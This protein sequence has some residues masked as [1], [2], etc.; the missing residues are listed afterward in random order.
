[1][2][3]PASLDMFKLESCS[4]DRAPGKTRVMEYN[5][6]AGGK[7]G[8]TGSGGSGGLGLRV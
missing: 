1:M 7:G 8:G 4:V 2:D 3:N 5:A 6:K